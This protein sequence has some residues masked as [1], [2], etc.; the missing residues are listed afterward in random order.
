MQ[1]KYDVYLCPIQFVRKKKLIGDWFK[2]F[3]TGDTGATTIAFTNMSAFKFPDS[4]NV[5]L[6]C[7]VEV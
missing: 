2:T 1:A 6:T 5:H 3:D 4:D 7:N